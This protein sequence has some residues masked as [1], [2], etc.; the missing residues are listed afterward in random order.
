MMA[1]FSN[2]KQIALRDEKVNRREIKSLLN[3][4]L[5]NPT[6]VKANLQIIRDNIIKNNLYHLID[7][8]HLLYRKL[9]KRKRVD[10][11]LRFIL[12]LLVNFALKKYT[13]YKFSNKN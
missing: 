2:H 10:E 3:T 8:I 12:K 5:T 9:L 7:S 1:E 4:L 13:N 6:Q 11:N